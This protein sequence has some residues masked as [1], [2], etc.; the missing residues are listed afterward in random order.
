M[1]YRSVMEL[2]AKYLFLLCDKGEKKTDVHRRLCV[3]MMVS[4]LILS[5]TTK[6][7]INEKELP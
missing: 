5:P 3:I 4:Q 7:K 6:Q 2:L 1:E